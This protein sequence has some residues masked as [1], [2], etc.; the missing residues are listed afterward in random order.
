M[1]LLAELEL[2]VTPQEDP[3]TRLTLTTE[4]LTELTTDD[5]HTVKGAAPYPPTLLPCVPTLH[6]CTTANTCPKPD[7]A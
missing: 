2:L 6:G 3:L 7:T 4:R 1:R 5:L